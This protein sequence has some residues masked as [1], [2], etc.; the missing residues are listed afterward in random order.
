M[1]AGLC[2]GWARAEPEEALLGKGQAYPIGNRAN[3]YINPYRVGSWSAMDQVRGLPTRAVA[4]GTG[5]S[6]LP[7]ASQ[8]PAIRWRFRNIGLGVDDYLERQRATGLLVIQNGRVVLERYRY[9]RSR[10]ARFL[11]FSMAKSVT[12]MLVGIALAR[13]A[14]ASLEDRADRYVPELAGSEYGKTAIVDLLR[15]SSGLTFTERYD[16]QDDIARLS[17]AAQTGDPSVLSVLRSVTQR[18]SPPGAKFSYASAETEVLGRVLSAA[19]GRTLA[20]LTHEWL[21]APLGAEADAFWVLA[22]DGQERASGFFNATLHDWGRLG[23]LVADGG[24]V[25]ATQVVPADYLLAATDAARQ[26]EAFRP[27]R[28]TPFFG[29]GFQFWLLPLQERTIAFQGV[30]GQAVFVQPASRIVMV[31]TAVF[32]A[33]SGRQDP[34]PLQERNA[35]WRGVLESLGGSTAELAA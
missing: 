28:A 32:E 21:W 30:H 34:Q 20:E 13:G 22:S 35:F 18:H 9:G 7:V 5:T 6:P 11:S 14:I 17:R 19:T 31:H 23:Q 10:D 25:G 29:Y 3:W 27:R 1:G 26:P 12:S 4:R 8:A 24:R 33:A 15:M 16:G 2:A